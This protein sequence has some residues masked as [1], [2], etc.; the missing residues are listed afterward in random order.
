MAVKTDRERE[1]YRP[2]RVGVKFQTIATDDIMSS[3]ELVE[4]KH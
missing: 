1:R 4:S 2:I 3:F